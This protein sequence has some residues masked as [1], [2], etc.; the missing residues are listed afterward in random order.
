[1]TTVAGDD[2][3]ALAVADEYVDAARRLTLSPL[4]SPGRDLREDPFNLGSFFP[5]RPG[6]PPVEP[7]SWLSPTEETLQEEEEEEEVAQ[8]AGERK[9]ELR[10]DGVPPARSYSLTALDDYA[11][12][13]IAKEDRLG[14][15]SLSESVSLIPIDI[16]LA[17]SCWRSRALAYKYSLI[18]I[19]FPVRIPSFFKGIIS[20]VYD[21]EDEDENDVPVTPTTLTLDEPHDDETL[22]ETL[23]SRR[24]AASASTKF[25]S[26]P[27]P[28]T[29]LA[30]AGLGAFSLFSPTAESGEGELGWAN[31]LYSSM[32]SDH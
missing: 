2:S 3:L 14:I 29:E 26:V 24:A 22:Y 12:E 7:L 20:T 28:S 23:C 21:E 9:A 1:M 4:T 25:G 13:V 8:E 31:A 17:A 6:E 11:K 18:Y 19:H 15:L 27:L 30:A 16:W 10:G 5:S 32:L